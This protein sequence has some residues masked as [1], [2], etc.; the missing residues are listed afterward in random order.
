MNWPR[1]NL[2]VSAQKSIIFT[3]KKVGRTIFSNGFQRTDSNN[4]SPLLM[5]KY[6]FKRMARNHNLDLQSQAHAG[7]HSPYFNLCGLFPRAVNSERDGRAGDGRVNRKKIGKK[8]VEA[9]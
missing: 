1:F 6:I 8:Q 2:S 5:A 3:H 9:D 7:V 4:Y